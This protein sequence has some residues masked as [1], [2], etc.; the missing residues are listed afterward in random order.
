MN[1]AH[2]SRTPAEIYDEMFVPALFAHWGPVICEIAQIGPGDLVLDVAC[3]TGALTRA[4]QE[5][6]GPK[7]RV[8]GLDPNQDMLSVARRR[9][10]DIEWREGKAEAI[11][12]P[13]ASF[14]AAVSQFGLMFFVDRAGALREMMRVLRPG[15]RLAVAV[16][17]AVENSPGYAAFADLLQ[18][19]FGKEIADAFRA[20]FTLGD[21]KKL[22]A[23][24]DEAG[25]GHAEILQRNELVRFSS[26]NAMVSTERACVWTLGGVLND[27]QFATL[28]RESEQALKPFVGADGAITFDMPAVII[29]TTKP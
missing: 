25:L 2:K 3:G 16:C 10:S 12:Y 21:P 18:Q 23:I 1:I 27:D 24:C 8:V 4:A 7:G 28:L 15:R 26:I 22:R 11:P 13:D 19:L 29:T 20:P 17:D 5:R 6:T 9:S 14:D